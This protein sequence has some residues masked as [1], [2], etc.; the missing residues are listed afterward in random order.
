MPL[1]PPQAVHPF[2]PRLGLLPRRVEPR[3]VG[4]CCRCPRVVPQLSESDA[5][6]CFVREGDAQELLEL[7]RLLRR[8]EARDGELRD[9][10]GHAQLAE[11]VEAVL[12]SGRVHFPVKVRLHADGLHRDAAR[13][14]V[15]ERVVVR[16]GGRQRERG[17][18]ATLRGAELGLRS[19][20]RR[21][22]VRRVHEALT[23]PLYP[24]APP[25]RILP[26]LVPAKGAAKRSQV[27]QDPLVQVGGELLA[28]NIIGPVARI[29]VAAV[30]ERGAQRQPA[31]L[32]GP[33]QQLL[34]GRAR[35]LHLAGR[36]LVVRPLE[37]RL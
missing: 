7:I 5:G 29:A 21:P 3:P 33:P 8:V 6:H 16:L 9:V 2:R 24:V 11:H 18:D 19:R 15:P 27:A 10:D 30:K 1:P 26:H 36:G 28:G 20:L 17:E 23:A 22:R 13:A 12:D 14:Q 25:E 37:L 31:V 35:V 32:G 4:A 34:R